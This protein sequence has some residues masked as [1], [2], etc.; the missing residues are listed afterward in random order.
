I[1]V[2]SRISRIF[3]R[4]TRVYFLVF[5]PSIG[6]KMDRDIGIERAVRT[7]PISIISRHVFADN[8]GALFAGIADRY[9]IVPI[10]NIVVVEPRILKKVADRTIHAGRSAWDGGAC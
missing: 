7:V 3:V 10:P 1:L 9:V 6:G 8:K 5:L 4:S 2:Q